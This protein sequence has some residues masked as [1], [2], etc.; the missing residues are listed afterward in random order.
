[1]VQKMVEAVEVP[2]GVHAEL[3]GN[4]V[5]VSASGKTSAREFKATDI[6]IKKEGTKIEVWAKS[7]KR[8]ILA[9]ARSAS[10]HIR[11]MMAGLGKPYE[12]KLEIVYSHFPLNIAIKDKHVEINNLGGAKHPRKAK[13]VGDSKVT[14][15]GKDVTVTGSS[16]E[17][18]GQTAANMEQAARIKG[19]D[20]RVFQDG[21]YIT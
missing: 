11:N 9:Q 1:M 15:K 18:T 12:Y 13:I 6:F 3:S 14:V 4:E 7:E 8:N 17:H 5:K 2:A 20:I 21:I 10:S 19:K 16:K